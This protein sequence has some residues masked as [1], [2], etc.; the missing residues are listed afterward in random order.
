VGVFGGKFS[1]G[2]TELALADEQAPFKAKGVLKDVDVN[3]VVSHFAGV[4]NLV[5]GRLNADIGLGGVGTTPALL[6]K[7][8]SGL[9]DG[10]VLDGEILAG[11]MIQGLLEPI[12]GKVNALPGVGKLIDTSAGTAKRLGDRAVSE[13][14]TVLKFTD[15]AMVLAQPLKA[16]T[17]SGPLR[18]DG[19]V[20]LAGQWDLTGLYTLT[21]A[22]ATALTGNRV[23]IDQPLPIRLSITGPIAHPK[24]APAAVDEVAK[25]F[26]VAFTK[27]AAGQALKNKL[28][29]GAGQLLDK[30]GLPGKIPGGA[31]TSVDDAK[32]KAEAQAAEQRARAQAEGERL[33]GE[34]E[35][36]R[37][38]AEAEARARTE[39]AKRKAAEQAKEKLRGLFGR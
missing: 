36:A 9:I 38:K 34:A 16:D 21:P 20:L 13:M 29:A 37:A 14:R 18:L 39:E 32:A 2:G 10:R 12:A 23:Q 17:K 35:A 31:P 30:S 3:T 11:D 4:P 6:A 19:R 24:V 5:K 26:I 1:G 25:V 8:L 33:R 15:G 28:G 7:N 22:A 27:S